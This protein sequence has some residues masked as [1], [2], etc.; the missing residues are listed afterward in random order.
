MASNGTARRSGTPPNDRPTSNTVVADD[1]VPEL[2]L[3]DDRHGFG[4]LRAHALGQP[5][6]G[7]RGGKCDLEMMLAGQPFLGRIGQNGAHHAA[8]RLLRQDV[9]ANVID[10]HVRNRKSGDQAIRRQI[11]A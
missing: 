5:H 7:R 3:Q 6:A 8:Q 10:R 9:V 11:R 4:I 2:M 1:Q